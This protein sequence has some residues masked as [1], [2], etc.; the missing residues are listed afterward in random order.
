MAKK[1]DVC[2]NDIGFI[3]GWDLSDGTM[4]NNDGKK[5]GLSHVSPNDVLVASSY[6]VAEIKELITNGEKADKK[7]VSEKT[8]AQSEIIKNNGADV[9][10][11]N[12]YKDKFGLNDLDDETE[13]HV[14]NVVKK[15]S[16]VDIARILGTVNGLMER[17]QITLN[18]TQ[19]EQNW[20]LIKQQ[21]ET[22]KLLRQLV[23]K[24]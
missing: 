18:Q 23:N 19:I 20:I 24:Q 8:K 12:A 16:N 2:G 13:Q 11:L 22:N 4:C 14:N 21:D 5:L 3:G 9:K 7:H 15:M 6:T 10:A 1:C 17:Y